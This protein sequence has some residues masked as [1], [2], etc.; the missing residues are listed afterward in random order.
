MISETKKCSCKASSSSKTSASIFSLKDVPTV[1]PTCMTLPLVAATSAIP[2]LVDLSL[3]LVISLRSPTCILLLMMFLIQVSFV[4]SYLLI[5]LL[6]SSMIHLFYKFIDDDIPFLDVTKLETLLNSMPFI[7][8]RFIAP[9][10]PSYLHA[11]FFVGRISQLCLQEF[12]PSNIKWN[13]T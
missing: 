8:V 3:H 5:F 1:T 10:I 9:L 13:M 12:G 7:I 11:P 2:A 6:A 4:F